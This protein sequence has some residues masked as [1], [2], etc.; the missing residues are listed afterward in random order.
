MK[1]PPNPNDFRRVHASRYGLLKLFMVFGVLSV[2]DVCAVKVRV[3]TYNVEHG[4]GRPGTEKYEA[5]K[6]SLA[7]VNADVVAFQELER[8]TANEWN[9]MAE[10]LGYPHRAWGELG[11]FSGN[12]VVGFWSRFPIKETHHVPAPKDSQEFSRIPLRILVD[13]PGAA[14][15][16]AMWNMH[17]KAMF[18]WRDD[19]RRAVEAFRIVRDIN[20]YCADKSYPV[21][22]VMFG[23]MNDDL[24]REEQSS[25]FLKPPSRLPST[26]RIGTD[27]EF[28]VRYRVFPT[29]HYS[30]A[31]GGMHLVPAFRQGSNNRITHLH[32]QYQLDYIF[33]SESVWSH[34][35]GRP[36]GEIYHSEW[37]RAEGGLQKAGSPL[38]PATSLRASDHYPV[39]V[40]LHV[41]DAE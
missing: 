31:G 40:D 4:V 28:P 33:V 12:M 13:I 6:S 5:L 32:T 18:Q 19:F 39:F 30:P 1:T 21:D 23:D 9:R 15:P 26:Y 16:L 10:E 38:D 11:T 20:Q 34:P 35:A 41:R 14:K 22:F 29:D 2:L 25:Q 3:A 7:R 36:E 27:L 24:E 37:D 8:K 17:H